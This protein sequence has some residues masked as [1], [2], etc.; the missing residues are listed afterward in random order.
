[1][2]NKS[3]TL[4]EPVVNDVIRIEIVCDGA[5]ALT[6]FK[7]HV[8]VASSDALASHSQSVLVDDPQTNL[9]QATKDAI[10]T[11]IAEA[12]AQYK[13]STNWP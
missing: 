10:T 3:V 4:T 7:A 1:M 12:L 2:V 11:V 6:K 8:N 9:P 13:I 5:G